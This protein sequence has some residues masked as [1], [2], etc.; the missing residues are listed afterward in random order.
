MSAPP[1]IDAAARR[2]QGIF[3]FSTVVLTTLGVVLGPRLGPVF[4]GTTGW[5]VSAALGLISVL[6]LV[7]EGIVLKDQTKS[8]DREAI[9]RI[10]TLGFAFA[11][12][13]ALYG[14]LIAIFTGE[15]LLAVPFGVFAMYKW[16]RSRNLVTRMVEA[17]NNGE[18][19]RL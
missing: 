5:V 19:P 8:A 9:S 3:I 11:E 10:A 4:E 6:G 17:I 13:T 14:L 7:S 16:L 15:G 1:P 12:T 18:I 2:L